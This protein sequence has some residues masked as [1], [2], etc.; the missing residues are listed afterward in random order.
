L[1]KNDKDGTRWLVDSFASLVQKEYRFPGVHGVVRKATLLAVLMYIG[2]HYTLRQCT[3]VPNKKGTIEM[4][5]QRIASWR[6]EGD[7]TSKLAY[8]TIM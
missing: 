4:L 5:L 3:H 8:I 2:F 6:K 7:P 1:R